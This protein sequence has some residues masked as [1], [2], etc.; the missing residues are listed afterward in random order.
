MSYL[1]DTNILLRFISPSDPNHRKTSGK[2]LA[3]D[4]GRNAPIGFSRLG[5][6]AIGITVLFVNRLAILMA[7]PC[8]SSNRRGKIK[9]S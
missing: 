5:S 7:N 4:M 1:A 2:P 8:Y 3:S 9:T 6:E